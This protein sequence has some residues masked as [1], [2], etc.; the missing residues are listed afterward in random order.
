MSFKTKIAAIKK[1][2][3][4]QSVSYGCTWKSKRERI[5]ATV[6]IGYAD[7]LS[8]LLSNRGNILVQGQS[9]P[10]RERVCMDQAMIDIT[11]IPNVQTG[12]MITIFGHNHSSFQSIDAIAGL[13]GTINYE[14]VCLIGKRVPRVYPEVL[15]K[16]CCKFG[17]TSKVLKS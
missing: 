7:G 5:I 11:D 6:P 16:A 12:D 1:V 4:S 15:E 13:M 3:V 2:A 17:N 8:R 9:A 14:V 10:I